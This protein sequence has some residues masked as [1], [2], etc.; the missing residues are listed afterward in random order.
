MKHRGER[1]VSS[2]KPFWKRILERRQYRRQLMRA[3][4]PLV[5]FRFWSPK[6]SPAIHTIMQS[7]VV[8]Y[9]LN[10]QI[11]LFWPPS[12]TVHGSHL[13]LEQFKVIRDHFQRTPDIHSVQSNKQIISVINSYAKAGGE[14]GQLRERPGFS[15][16]VGTSPL[17]SKQIISVINSY[18]SAGGER[19]QLRERPGFSGDVGTSPLQPKGERNLSVKSKGSSSLSLEPESVKI[20]RAKPTGAS[21]LILAP[22][23]VQNLSAEPKDEIRVRRLV[24]SGNALNN[25][26]LN[27]DTRVQATPRVVSNTF[28]TNK[29]FDILA[30]QRISVLP[31][32]AVSRLTRRTVQHEVFFRHAISPELRRNLG[33]KP[34]AALAANT[35]PT[36]FTKT[37]G[38]EAGSLHAALPRL[39]ALPAWRNFVSAPA[40]SQN[41][42]PSSQEKAS[43]APQFS[44]VPPPPPPLDIG[45]LSEEVYRHIQRKIR[46]ERERRGL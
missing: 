16:D 30:R 23:S 7:H 36:V 19:E 35:P 22:N 12:V 25:A 24:A 21:D 20:K 18:A 13:T 39:Y 15:G 4:V 34:P 27:R 5:L 1:A 10:L 44:N 8:R 32:T 11:Q 40:N 6:Y 26:H 38:E 2:Q 37:S 29:H 33:V 42:A 3:R 41:K 43:P 31:V 9:P 28:L 45:R 14:R 46:V 17:E